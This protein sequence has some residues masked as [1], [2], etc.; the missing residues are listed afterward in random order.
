MIISFPLVTYSKDLNLFMVIVN[1][2]MLLIF[3]ALR[4]Q[5]TNGISRSPQAPF[6]LMVLPQRSGRNFPPRAKLSV[7]SFFLIWNEEFFPLQKKRGEKFG[8]L[9][10]FFTSFSAIRMNVSDGQEDCSYFFGLGRSGESP[11]AE[12]FESGVP[13]AFKKRSARGR[14]AE[15]GDCFQR[16]AEGHGARG[17]I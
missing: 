9:F 16:S 15:R 3:C 8:M 13:T 6:R 5:N 12:R 14:R 11:R 17:G 1:R 10:F 2:E 7:R 4:S